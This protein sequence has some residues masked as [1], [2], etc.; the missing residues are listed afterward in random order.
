[1]PNSFV[2]VLNVAEVLRFVTFSATSGMTA[3]EGSV[4]MPSTEPSLPNC[5]RPGTGRPSTSRTAR[6][7]IP[8][9]ALWVFM[10]DLALLLCL[11]RG[12]AYAA[13][14]VV[15]ARIGAERFQQGVHVEPDHSVSTLLV[16]FFQ[17][18]ERLLFVAEARV[19]PYDCERRHV[20]G[21]FRFH[22]LQFAQQLQ[23]FL[24]LAGPRVY[25]HQCPQDKGLSLV[26]DQRFLKF[27]DGLL[28]H[29]LLHVG[30]GEYDARIRVTRVQLQRLLHGCHSFV[31]PPGVEVGRPSPGVD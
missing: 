9:R 25:V 18:G 11:S 21:F 28:V 22:S 5:A 4:T 19:G 26:K 27:C 2:I 12:Q 10:A 7:F 3:P 31:S 24:P 14:E 13:H 30:P 20:S 15:E 16:G 23:R 6:I 8:C 29:P 17:P 1:M